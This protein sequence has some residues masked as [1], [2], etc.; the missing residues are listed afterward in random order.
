MDLT[1]FIIVTAVI[2][3]GFLY[4]IRSKPKPF[5]PSKFIGE[6]AFVKPRKVEY[7]ED[8]PKYSGP[9]AFVDPR[10]GR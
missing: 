5:K 1:F 4:L 9:S 2:G 8:K 7:D 3:I 6:S 10:T